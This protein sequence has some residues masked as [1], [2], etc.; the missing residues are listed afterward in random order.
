MQKKTWIRLG[1]TTLLVGGAVGSMT[2]AGCGGDDNTG[3]PPKEAGADT[4]N[5][6]EG[7]GTDS[8][9]TDGPASEGG[10]A[11][12][13]EGGTKANAKVYLVNAAS[14]PNAPPLRFCF[15]INSAGDGG[16]TVTV[17]D[18]IPPYP[19]T[20]VS[21]AFPIA[22]LFSGFGGLVNGSG[23][24]AAFNLGTLN[25]TLYAINA[26][27]IANNTAD[28]GP[29][30][31]AEEICENYV[32]TDGKGTAGT[33][34]GSLTLGTDYWN[35]GTIPSCTAS[36]GACLAQTQTWV[37]AVT[38]C[39][40]GETGAAA[41]ACPTG[42]NASTGNVGLTAWQLDNTTAVDGGNSGAQ[43]ANA[44]SAWDFI[45]TASGGAGTAAGFWQV[46]T[47]EAGA[48]GD[49]GGDDGSSDAAIEAAPPPQPTLVFTP[50]AGPPDTSY[51]K[52]TSPAVNVP[53]ALIKYDPQTAG[54][55]AA[56]VGADAGLVEA[57]AGCNPLLGNCFSP[58]LFPLPVIDAYSGNPT[59]G[60]EYAGGKTNVFILLG[61]PSQLPYIGAD[62]G[63]STTPTNPPVP[64]GK[65]AH[66]LSFPTSNP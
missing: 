17:T 28:G 27:A 57:P 14:D 18:A 46:V 65:S 62:G 44:S 52:I 35:L 37:A 22:G 55:A 56:L 25:I 30:G 60:T 63:P 45:G 20:R 5:P 21:A 3:T 7:G 6:A 34:G 40:P 49:D 58:L 66:I 38:G 2:V 33:G 24:L 59:D 12:G 61:D 47:P 48:P 13:G 50:I 10:N 54:F 36:P 41:A 4:T 29:D 39:F 26:I 64:N 43:F 42:Y 9:K 23:K 32:G 15:G 1:L 19:D 53:T 31:G 8:S 11:E 16:G 51:G